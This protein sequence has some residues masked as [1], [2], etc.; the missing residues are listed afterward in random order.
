MD[1]EDIMVKIFYSII[2]GVIMLCIYF[3][4]VDSG[5][6]NYECIDT[7]GNTRLCERVYSDHGTNWGIALDGNKV[8]IIEYR[9][10]KEPIES[11]E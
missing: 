10:I 2:I 4:F 3:S 9:R 11:E 7:L 1:F 6:T 8:Q 5:K